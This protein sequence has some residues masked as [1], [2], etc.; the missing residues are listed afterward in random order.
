[1]FRI[2]NEYFIKYPDKIR[3]KEYIDSIY[4][5]DLLN[6]NSFNRDFITVFGSLL[7]KM[8]IIKKGERRWHIYSPY[9]LGSTLST[10]NF[11]KNNLR[12]VVDK[13]VSNL[14][15]YYEKGLNPYFI[16]SLTYKE[17]LRLQGF[18]DD[19]IF[20]CSNTI[21]AKIIG[22]AITV[23]VGAAVIKELLPALDNSNKIK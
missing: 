10:K 12:C 5:D 14:Q 3:S 22:N 19:Y 1:M 11:Q 21:F 6:G 9:D 16:R 4:T 8:E 13:K 18:P 7:W 2:M 17:H 23:N 15:E 20:N